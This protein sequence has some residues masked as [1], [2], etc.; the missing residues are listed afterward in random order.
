VIENRMINS[1]TVANCSEIIEASNE[2]EE[3]VVLLGWGRDQS[4]FV[5]MF[6]ISRHSCLNELIS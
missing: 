6:G 5:K 3:S 4:L 1:K 2:Q